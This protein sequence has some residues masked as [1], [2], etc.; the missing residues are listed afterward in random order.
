MGVQELHP[1]QESE[2]KQIGLE[3]GVEGPVPGG[4]GGVREL[5]ASRGAARRRSSFQ[6]EKMDFSAATKFVLLHKGVH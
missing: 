6:G 3:V 1:G 2:K 4:G 5:W